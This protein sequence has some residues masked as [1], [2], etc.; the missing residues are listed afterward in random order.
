MAFS[1]ELKETELEKIAHVER[2]PTATDLY[3]VHW[4]YLACVWR[5]PRITTLWRHWQ[6]W[7][8]RA[9]ADQG[10]Q[11]LYQRAYNARA[12]VRKWFL[13]TSASLNSSVS[14]HVN[15]CKF[16]RIRRA[17]DLQ[18]SS[19]PCHYW[20]LWQDCESTHG[21]SWLQFDQCLCLPVSVISAQIN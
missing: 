11:L 6:E 13:F 21:H 18:H 1:R 7:A 5:G 19:E 8:S 2:D 9:V 3:I 10:S 15:E 14:T 4:I 17:R 12:W 20:L 16:P